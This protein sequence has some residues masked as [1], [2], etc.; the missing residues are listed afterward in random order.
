DLGQTNFFG[1]TR[2][3]LAAIKFYRKVNKPIGGRL[4]QASSI[5]GLLMSKP[6]LPTSHS[7]R[8]NNRIHGHRVGSCIEQGQSFHLWVTLM[9]TLPRS[10]LRKWA[11]SALTLL[12]TTPTPCNHPAYTAPMLLGNVTRAMLANIDPKILK[13][14]PDKLARRLHKLARLEDPPLRVVLGAEGPA[15]LG[16]KLAKDE[17]EKEKYAQWAYGLE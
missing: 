3:S 6:I 10:P 11:F 4:I 15:M 16:P 9:V 1:A 14:D 17:Q 7:T 8:G 12:K 13:G 5:Y 2:V